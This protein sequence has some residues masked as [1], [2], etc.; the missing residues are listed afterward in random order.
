MT[1]EI[2]TSGDYVKE[3]KPDDKKNPF[4]QIYD[5]KKKDVLNILNVKDKDILDLGGGMGR[6]SVPLAKKNRVV[7]F[8]LSD[9]MLKLAKQNNKDGRLWTIQG[10]ADNPLPFKDNT[11]DIIVCLDLIVHVKKP[12]MMISEIHRVLRKDGTLVI[13]SSN[14]NPAWIFAYPKYTGINPVRITKTMLA[15]GVL[16]E[17]QKQV[18]HFSKN[19]F[20][21]MLKNHFRIIKKIDYGPSFASKW[22]LVVAKKVDT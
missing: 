19:E 21:K 22:N 14:K 3:F 5:K 12:P 1:K 11:F 2:F 17:W 20:Y 13:D 4:Q 16:P 10:D 15:G 6:I 8:D 18:T 9:A 7:L